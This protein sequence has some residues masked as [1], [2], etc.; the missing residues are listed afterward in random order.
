MRILVTGCTGFAGGWLAEALTEQ[1]G[2]EVY[3]ISRQPVRSG[4]TRLAALLPCDLGERN[5][6]GDVLQTA[7]PERI[8]HL[9][10][11]AQVGESF[12]EADRAWAANLT[13]TRNLYEAILQTGGRPR[14][15]YVSSALIYG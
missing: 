13:A 2:A 7:Q 3:G 6:I 14:V 9:A 1:P 12:R 11:Y 8:Y 10:G 4:A 5:A 15:L